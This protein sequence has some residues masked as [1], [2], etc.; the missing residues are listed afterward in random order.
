MKKNNKDRS[1]L[2]AAAESVEAGVDLLIENEA[3]RA[4]P[5][6][7][8]IVKIAKGV[9]DYRSRLLL[10]K[11]YAFLV[12]PAL[13]T[14]Q[15]S[16]A[17]RTII[18]ADEEKQQDIG[19]TLFLVLDKI[20]DLK[21]PSLLAKIFVAYLD[22]QIDAQVFLML[23]HCI[24]QSHLADLL[25]LLNN[26]DA[27]VANDATWK[28]RLVSSGLISAQV[29]IV[30]EYNHSYHVYGVSELGKALIRSVEY[31]NQASS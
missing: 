31:A 15:E 2:E 26:S 16:K 6:V 22:G 19:D 24:D 12:E 18:L 10:Q 25:A 11:L 13:Q 30:A 28:S 17:L 9:D 1:F 27:E 20:T 14:R 3:I 8:S 4:I 5:F 29:D 21:K 23:A 7:G